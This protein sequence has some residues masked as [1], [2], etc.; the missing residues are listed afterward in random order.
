[1][2]NENEDNITVTAVDCSPYS[3]EG[4]SVK[5]LEASEMELKLENFCSYG[6]GYLSIVDSMFYIFLFN[7]GYG[8]LVWMTVVEI[9]PPQIRSISNGFAVG[10]VGI[11]SFIIMFTFP[12]LMSSSYA[13]K[14]AFWMYSAVSLVGFFFIT[15]FVPETRGKTEKEIRAYFEGTSEISEEESPTPILRHKH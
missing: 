6:L 1:M 11:L 2:M 4:I 10:W 15:M 5:N 3:V 9:I 13:G 12:F 8:T 14:W 7:L